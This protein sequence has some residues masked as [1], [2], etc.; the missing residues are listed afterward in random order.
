MSVWRRKALEA[1]PENKKIIESVENPMALWIELHLIFNSLVEENAKNPKI[2]KILNYASWCFSDKSGK[3]PNDTSTAVVCAFYEDI[4]TQREFWP[5]FKEW[6]Y[7]H[8]FEKIKP[9]FKYHL[10]DDE[11]IE[12]EKI[13]KMKS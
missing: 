4:A 6:F 10:S 5:Y 8:E 9:C 3:L 12:L 2:R 7:P 1:L 13:Y 11:F